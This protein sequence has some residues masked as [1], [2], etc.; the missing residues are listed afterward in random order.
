[1][2][3]EV[4]EVGVEAPPELLES[5][6]AALKEESE[7]TREEDLLAYAL[8]LGLHLE[9]LEDRR[10]ELE[11]AGM[12]PQG[13]YDAMYAELVRLEGA[14][15]RTRH[16]LAEA[17]RDYQTGRMTNVALRR[18]VAA[19]K[20][21]LLPRLEEERVRLRQRRKALLRALETCS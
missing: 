2:N 15:A 8:L 17:A 5:L 3:D 13:V 7:Y 11:G 6:R 19:T 14:Y 4:I 9:A 18:E 1:L 21:I 10:E 20:T 16:A 12:D